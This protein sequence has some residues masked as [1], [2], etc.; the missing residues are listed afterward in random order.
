MRRTSPRAARA[1]S[2][3]EKRLEGPPSRRSMTRLAGVALCVAVTLTAAACSSSKGSSPGTG[4][5]ANES[6][7]PLVYIGDESNTGGQATP[8]LNAFKAAVAAANAHGGGIHGHPISLTVCD[9]Q[10]NENAA[11]ACGQQAVS[12]HAIAVVD[13]SGEEDTM[14]PY[15]QAADIPTFDN[16]GLPLTWTSPVS[17]IINADFLAVTAGA[18]A[19]LAKA[20]CTSFVTV[21][22]EY[23][24]VTNGAIDKQSAAA[25]KQFGIQDK[26]S[27][28]APLTA[29]DMSA[30]VT[31]AL[32]KA[33]DC[34]ATQA[35]GS[36]EISL[37]TALAPVSSIKE[38]ALNT[39]Y[40]AS[41]A[42]QAQ[43]V[44][45]LMTRLGSRALLVAGDEGTNAAS[46]NP[47]VRQFVADHNTYDPSGEIS[48]VAELEWSDLQLV[49]RA[50]DA[51]YPN[52]TA[53]GLLKYLNQLRDYW[54]GLTPAVSFNK[55]VANPYGPR[56]EAVWVADSSWSATGD[57][58][59]IGPW[60]NALTGATTNN[61]EP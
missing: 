47:A 40:V 8:A 50:A 2:G 28:Y 31:E 22:S 29:P 17:F 10:S 58:P 27:V 53:D 41:S 51:V 3:A 13:D 59:R 61:N 33:P 9:A 24:S 37:L 32:N 38:I 57:S 35:F 56:I 6:G 12:D 14:F 23:N 20:G 15:L 46:W 26:G 45:A 34:I 42:S 52:V 55:P 5:A 21:G 19:L 43:A 48:G 30:Y 1:H 44:N 36:S 39:A 4:T 25:A 60:V 54:P 16:G 18:V 11:A 49:I 7:Y